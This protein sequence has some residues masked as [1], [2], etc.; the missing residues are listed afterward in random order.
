ML[1]KEDLERR[2]PFLPALLPHELLFASIL[3][4]LPPSLPRPDPRNTWSPSSQLARDGE[5]SS[6]PD[7]SSSTVQVQLAGVVGSLPDPGLQSDAAAAASS[8]LLPEHVLH[9]QRIHVHGPRASMGECYPL[10]IA[11]L[12]FRP[13]VRPS[14]QADS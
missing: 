7:V 3:S 5:C 11:L 9:E 6:S 2:W 12:S 13:S 10:W 8:G 4:V 1:A 14:L